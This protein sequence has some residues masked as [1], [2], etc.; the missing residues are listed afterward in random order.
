MRK[1][2]THHYIYKTINLKNGMF[3]VGMHSTD[4]L[5]DGYLGSGTRLRRSIRKNGVQNFKLEIIEFLPNREALKIREKEL[6]NEDLIKNDTC[7]N[8]AIGGGGGFIN[9][10]HRK[11]FLEER[12]NKNAPKLGGINGQKV[13]AELRKNPEFNAKWKEAQS[14]GLKGKT[15]WLGKVHKEE[16]KQKIGVTNSIKQ[17]GERNSQFGTCW[18]TNGIENKKIKKEEEIP[19]NWW[20]GRK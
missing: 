9:D 12:L 10:E 18:I 13:L 1:E 17:K 16:T 20:L 19:T 14:N 15:N 8:I 11:K 7:L 2:K 6:V 4:N 5:N 3:Y